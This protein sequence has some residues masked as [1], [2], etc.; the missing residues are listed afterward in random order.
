VSHK[1]VYQ[2]NR[3]MVVKFKPDDSVETLAVNAR[4]PS[5]ALDSLPG[6]ASSFK[7]Y[8][9]VNL[10]QGQLVRVTW[11][12]QNSFYTTNVDPS[13]LQ[14]SASAAAEAAPLTSGG[15]TGGDAQEVSS[16]D[17]EDQSSSD[18][19]EEGV[20]VPQVSLDELLTVKG[21]V[22]QQQGRSEDP[23]AKTHREFSAKARFPSR[24][25]SAADAH[26]VH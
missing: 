15:S 24:Q 5:R 19:E 17:D 25:V 7:V 23:C 21:F 6:D 10:I 1:K 22:W 18:D 26:T 8:G 12:I 11:K 13:D 4:L 20:T 2:G 16:S 14:C 3:A 9:I